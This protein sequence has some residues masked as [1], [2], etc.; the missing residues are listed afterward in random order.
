MIECFVLVKEKYKKVCKKYISI[1][2]EEIEEEY[3]DEIICDEMRFE[4]REGWCLITLLQEDSFGEEILVRLSN[5]K[6]LI[7]FYSDDVQMDCEFLVVD[8]GKIIRKKY[9]YAA[10]PQLNEDEGVLQCE[11]LHKFTEWND[12]DYFIELARKTPETLFEV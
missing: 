4:D 8:K 2:G 10:T 7:Y 11:K 12:I 6:K 3:D 9:I 1:T 5:K